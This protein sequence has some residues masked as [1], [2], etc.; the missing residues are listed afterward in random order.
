M[1]NFSNFVQ[2]K[3]FQIWRWIDER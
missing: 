2:G 1:Q 3:H